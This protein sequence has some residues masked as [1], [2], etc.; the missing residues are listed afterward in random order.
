[1]FEMLP[2]FVLSALNFLATLLVFAIGCVLLGIAV[3]Y[4]IDRTQTTNTVR[5]NYPVIGHGRYFLGG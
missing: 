2:S 4:I 1:M 5:R 3:L